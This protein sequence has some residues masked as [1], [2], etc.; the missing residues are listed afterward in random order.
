MSVYRARA[1]RHGVSIPASRLAKWKTFAQDWAIGFCV[2]PIT[3]APS[4]VRVR[5]DLDR[6]RADASTPGGSTTTSGKRVVAGAR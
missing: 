5:D 3:G 6:R 2:L 4:G 1:A